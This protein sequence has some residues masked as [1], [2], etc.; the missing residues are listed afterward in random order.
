MKLTTQRLK[1][2]I[3]EELNKTKRNIHENLLNM[4][5]KEKDLTPEKY[6]ERNEE[7]NEELLDFLEKAAVDIYKSNDDYETDYYATPGQLENWYNDNKREVSLIKFDRR[8][9]DPEQ[10]WLDGMIG[11]DIDY[12][13]SVDEFILLLV[14]FG[15]LEK[16][17]DVSQY[18]G[19]DTVYEFTKKT[20]KQGK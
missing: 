9:L 5:P 4:I 10:I 14:T 19:V 3:R 16:Q 18:Y 7:H 8:P 17:E 2:L 1:K 15:F 11:W 12:G 6:I 20:T 13:F